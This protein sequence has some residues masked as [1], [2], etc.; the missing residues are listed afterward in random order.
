LQA[1]AQND[2][3]INHDFISIV[4]V[5][6]EDRQRLNTSGY[7]KILKSNRNNLAMQKILKRNPN[8]LD[9]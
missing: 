3:D 1:I 8:N 6:M 2:H 9:M 4:I 7:A 5:A